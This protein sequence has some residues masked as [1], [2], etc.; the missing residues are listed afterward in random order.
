VFLP[1]RVA[2]DLFIY[3]RAADALIIPGR[4]GIVISE[5]MAFE[6]PVIVFQADG[7][8][9]DLVQNKITGIQLD[10]CDVEDFKNAIV[11]LY[12][13]PDHCREMGLNGK[14]LINNKYNT[15]N[16][17]SVIRDAVTFVTSSSVGRSK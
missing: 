11:Y 5:G 10:G 6:L 9:C 13:N 3:Y 4:G 17:S 15:K 12:N 1:G 14:W 7:T 8:E 2:D 16:M